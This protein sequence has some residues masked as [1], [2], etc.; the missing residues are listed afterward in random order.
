MKLIMI[1]PIDKQPAIK[2][3]EI[4]HEKL[5]SEIQVETSL[6]LIKVFQSP[7][8]RSYLQYYI[9]QIDSTP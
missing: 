2:I 3:W 1:L 5:I 9:G 7:C 4:K 8:I 6:L